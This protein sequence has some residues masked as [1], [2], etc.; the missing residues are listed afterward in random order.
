MAT[1][2]APAD[3]NIENVGKGRNVQK[4]TRGKNTPTPPDERGTSPR[5]MAKMLPKV[6]RTVLGKRGLAEGGIV[7]GWPEI[8]GPELAA[9]CQPERLNIPRHGTGPGTLHI[10]VTGGIALELQH[11]APL[12]IERINGHYGYQ[13]VDKLKFIHAPHVKRH[14]K[15]RTNVVPPPLTQTQQDQLDQS[16]SA[17]EDPELRSILDRIGSSIIRHG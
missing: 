8:V 14:E 3:W 1:I 11:L 2:M 17:V 12:V 5:P 9:E 10:L 15:R 13:A 4:S 7:D 16:L 6:T